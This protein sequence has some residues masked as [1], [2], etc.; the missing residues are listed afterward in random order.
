MRNEGLAVFELRKRNREASAPAQEAIAPG[1]RF[2]FIDALRGVAC[3]S[4]L[5]HHLLHGTVLTAALFALF[6]SWIVTAGTWGAHGVEVF[7]VISGF[8][9]AHSL[10]QFEPSGGY[11]VNFAVRRQLRLDPVY[12]VVV[13]LTLGVWSLER[14]VPGLVTAPL[15]AGTEIA[16]NLG[17]AMNFL[18][19]PPIVSVAWTLCIELQFYLV[20]L[21]VLLLGRWLGG[22]SKGIRCAAL[23][24]ACAGLMLAAMK[25]AARPYE[26]WFMP[27]WHYF[28]GGALCYWV[29]TRQIPGWWYVVFLSGEVAWAIYQPT[30]EKVTGLIVCAAV[31]TIGGYGL[32]QRCSGGRILQYLGSR[33]YS[34]YLIHLL[35]LTMVMRMGYKLTGDRPWAAL[36]WFFA[37]AGLSVAAGE[38]LHRWVERPSL[39]W[40][41]AFKQTRVKTATS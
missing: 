23:V 1:Q 38:I 25:P 13:L 39:K 16:A 8:V 2:V 37:A 36:G 19:M 21:G 26:A 41:A 7:F 11:I 20:F 4:V 18:H 33:S 5:F 27:F 34:I 14:K 30:P 40:A 29:V 31:L 22:V 35:V 15:P 32:L 9:I 24:G 12:W 17:Y 3:L 10:R 28:I 6:P